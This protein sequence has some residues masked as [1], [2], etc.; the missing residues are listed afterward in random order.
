M[1]AMQIVNLGAPLEAREIPDPAPGPGEALLRVRACGVNFADT[2]MQRGAYQEKPP[3][4][5]TPGMEVCGVVE[6]LG[7]GAAGPPPGTRVACHAGGGGFAELL[8]APA[9]AC[10]PAPAALSDAEVAGFPVAYATSHIALAHLARLR[11]G[12]TLA[13]LGASGG[14][15][16][17]AVELGRLAG[18]RVIAVA[19]TDAGR[20]AAA[21][22]GAHH[23]LSGEEPDLRGALRALGGIDVLYDAVGGAQFEAA[24]R[25]CRPEARILPIGFASG[26]IPQIPANILLV[27]NLSVFGFYL[28]GFARHHPEVVA[29]A[30]ATLFAWVEAGRLRPHVSHT[31]PLEE[32]NAAL[33]LLRG[34]RAT[35]KVVVVV[36][37]AVTPVTQAGPDRP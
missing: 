28:G 30:F 3:L 36:N 8:V 32:A 33:E 5:A 29:D 14:V 6:A 10:A 11:P 24:F 16:L 31:L 13:V 27:K 2:L 25:A 19:R 12:E 35:G 22:A 1:R 23:L 17:T 34:R 18:A 9:A 20:A 15:G 7:P 26:E 4:P 21:A 37:A